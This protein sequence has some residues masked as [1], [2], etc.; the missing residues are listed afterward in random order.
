MIEYYGKLIPTTIEELVDPNHS[1]LVVVDVQNDFCVEDGKLACPEMV[2][3]LKLLIGEA[4][5]TGV[6]LVHIQ[7]TLL[8]NRLSDSAAWIRHYMV[9]LRTDDPRLVR[10]SA[11]D[12]TWGHE[13]VD[14]VKPL[15]GEITIKKYRSSAFEG[16]PLDLLRTIGIA[17]AVLGA[18]LLIDHLPASRLR[19]GVHA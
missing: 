12:G 1:A 5:R 15:K 4:R 10:E 16:T 3:D 11:V 14:D 9:G 2:N 8:P 17:V 13:I 6:M 7:D 18:M 19:Q